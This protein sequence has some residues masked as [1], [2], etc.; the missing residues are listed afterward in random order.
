MLII[1]LLVC[2]FQLIWKIT[3]MIRN[4]KRFNRVMSK[5]EMFWE[6][7]KYGLESKIAIEN[8]YKIAKNSLKFMLAIIIFSLPFYIAQ[9]FIGDT[10]KL[11]YKVYYPNNLNN[12][13]AYEFAFVFDFLF[14]ILAVALLVGFDGLFISLIIRIICE[15]KLLKRSLETLKINHEIKGDEKKNLKNVYRIIDHHNLIL[16]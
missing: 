2:Y 3:V 13:P 5:M 8:I 9:S 11:P 16:R 15:L 12:S 4:R 7:D 10:R 14:L 1:L 6:I